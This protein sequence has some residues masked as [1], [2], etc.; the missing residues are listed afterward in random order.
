[1]FVAIVKI[2]LFIQWI[3]EVGDIPILITE[4]ITVR[5]ALRLTNHLNLIMKNDWQTVINSILEKTV[6]P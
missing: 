4:V 5:E 1:M 3:E 6:I 2:E